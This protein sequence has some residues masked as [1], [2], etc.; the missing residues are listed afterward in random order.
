[1]EIDDTDPSAPNRGGVQ[2]SG[3][4]TNSSDRTAPET[5]KTELKFLRRISDS[6]LLTVKIMCS[7]LGPI[8]ISPKKSKL[9][10]ILF[11]CVVVFV[12]CFFSN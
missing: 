2:S 12:F 4:A 10:R 8:N 11:D 7:K 9:E 1:M 3:D 5:R 6:T